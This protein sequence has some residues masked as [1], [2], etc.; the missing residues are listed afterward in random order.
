[1]PQSRFA[2]RVRASRCGLLLAMVSCWLLADQARTQE[3][4]PQPLTAEQR[5]RLKERDRLTGEAQKLAQAGKLPELIAVLEKELA[6]E[7][8]VFG[9]LH[10][11]VADSLAMLARRYQARQ[12]FATARKALQE[13]VTIRVQL[14]GAED[15]RVT[16]ARLALEDLGLRE[17]LEPAQRARLVEA[18]RLNNQGFQLWRQS[19]PA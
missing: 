1:M 5:E 17:K 2:M 15:W 12:D 18:T 9:N 7:R 4:M 14:H 13:V 11:D 19:K 8:E 3:P 10:A 6:I 16:D